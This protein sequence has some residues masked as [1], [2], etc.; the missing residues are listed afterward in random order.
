V[1]APN[2]GV[3]QISSVLPANLQRFDL[4]RTEPPQSIISALLVIPHSNLRA[5]ANRSAAR[6]LML[7]IPK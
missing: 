3:Q 5:N 1:S 6:S 4:L 7:H 2:H